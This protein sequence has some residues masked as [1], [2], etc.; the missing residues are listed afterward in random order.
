MDSSVLLETDLG[1][2]VVDL[3]AKAAPRA[4]LNFIRL[5]EIG[6]YVNN[7]FFKIEKDFVAMCGDPT[8]SSKTVTC[9]ETLRDKTQYSNLEL[10]IENDDETT[11][12]GKV[13]CALKPANKNVSSQFFFTLSEASG[14]SYAHLRKNHTVLGKVVEDS[15]NVL[16]LLSETFADSSGRPLRDIRLRK[17]Y[18]LVYPPNVE[19]LSEEEIQSYGN[20]VPN[21]ITDVP[22]V[23][24]DV[25]EERPSKFSIE[26]EEFDEERREQLLAEARAIKLE[27]LG[28]ITSADAKPEENVLFVCKLNPI[29][30]SENLQLIFSRF[31]EIRDCE[32]IR[33]SKT[34]ES[35]QYAF[36]TFAAKE[37]CEEAYRKM[38]D[39]MIDGRRI[40]VDFSQSA[41]KRR[42]SNVFETQPRLSSSYDQQQKEKSDSKNRN[43]SR[44]EED[45]VSSSDSTSSSTDR[46]KHK[47]SSKKHKKK[48]SRH[49]HH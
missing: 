30:T 24:W 4:V 28:D 21:P 14:L 10:E 3:R 49:H 6:Y 32:V 15:S 33:D 25:I 38:Q 22:A 12:K 26:S 1:V 43:R 13:L 41:G 40:K 36:I 9:F 46:R 5:C 2:I 35:L 23:E 34:K 7:L 11:W 19:P 45:S 16:R 8:G 29:T 17:T 18:V 48:K 44:E 42:R 39:V 31:G 37:S 20:L 47:K 27:I